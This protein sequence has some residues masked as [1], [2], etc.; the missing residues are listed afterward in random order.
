MEKGN[1]KK[2]VL[3]YS[4][5]FVIFLI[6]CISIYTIYLSNKD[7]AFS[8]NYVCTIIGENSSLL[9]KNEYESD[10]SYLEKIIYLD[11]QAKEN[12]A[13]G[14]DVMDAQ[15]LLYIGALKGEFIQI[16][17]GTD[18]EDYRM[19]LAY[20][21][22]GY[23]NNCQT[24]KMV[25]KAFD[26]DENEIEVEKYNYSID[27]LDKGESVYVLFD[28]TTADGEGYIVGMYHKAFLG[29]NSN[30]VFL[31]VVMKK[32]NVK[33][34]IDDEKQ[35]EKF[36]RKYADY[37][38]IQNTEKIEKDYEEVDIN[39][40]V[41]Y[42]RLTSNNWNGEYHQDKYY[43]SEGNNISKVVSYEDYLKYID[44]INNNIDN[45][46]SNYYTD[47]QSNYIILSYA[48]GYG[49]CEI[50]L[51]DCIEENNRIIIYGDE[52]INGV[53]SS[54]SGYFI[55][56]PTDMPTG[57][58]IEYRACYSTQEI[59]NL[60]NY[61][62]FETDIRLDK[63]II[64]L[65]PTKETKLNVKLGNANLVTCI[66]PEYDYKYGWNVL[67][68][69]NGDLI[70]LNTNRS[71]YALYYESKAI[72]DYKVQ[73]DGFIVK[74]E[75]VA[76]FLEEK[77]EV[78]G[79]TE[80]EAQEFI[81]YWLPILQKNKYNY[82]R[83]AT[84]EEINKSMPLDFSIKPDTLIRVLMTYKGMDKPIQI[85][86]QKLNKPKRTGFVVVEWGGSQIK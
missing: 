24:N 48:N 4:I 76:K 57:T 65:Y 45:K 58:N 83:F 44:S 20:I 30:V 11:E 17:Y 53:M 22:D 52:D 51:I 38:I 46:I 19:L 68:K 28:I 62:N 13:T 23:I 50:D 6:I 18:Y 79:L 2:M 54:G 34:N 26:K 29:V 16:K 12:M 73:K 67:A 9:Y 1:R 25:K 42:H 75:D 72:Y 86:E 49:W 70:D 5:L 37:E 56:I 32:E 74:G 31:T 3:K 59:S 41:Y 69:P 64:Y 82:I 61:G 43:T 15:E 63:P 33:I 78:L 55:A 10:T 14:M 27:K 36:W 80:R 77:L 85:K 71:L 7:N 84:L 39:G 8:N 47:E 40:T 66:Y 35:V 60:K 81:I 21:A